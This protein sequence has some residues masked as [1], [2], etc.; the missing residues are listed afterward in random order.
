ML[1][2]SWVADEAGREKYADLRAQVERLLDAGRNAAALRRFLSGIGMP[3]AFIAL[4]PLMPG[5]RAMVAL[6][7]TLRYDMALTADLPPVG[8]AGPRARRRAQPRRAAHCRS[9]AGRSPRPP[10]DDARRAEP[11]GRGPGAAPRVD[12]GLGAVSPHPARSAAHIVGVSATG[13]A[14]ATPRDSVTL[15]WP[16][17]DGLIWPML[18]RAGVFM[19][20]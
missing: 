16:R 15:I 14:L 5:W 20:V 18:R 10:G 13:Y 7:P 11:H 9:P 6:A 17:G 12:R 19:S 3:R 2:R 8:L 1:F 4:L